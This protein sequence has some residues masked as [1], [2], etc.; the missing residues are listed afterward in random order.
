MR[1][2]LYQTDSGNRPVNERIGGFVEPEGIDKTVR[3]PRPGFTILSLNTPV[4][5]ELKY[6][7]VYYKNLT[8]MPSFSYTVRHLLETHPALA[9]L[10]ATLYTTA[11]AKNEPVGLPSPPTGRSDT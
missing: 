1:Q 11:R 4:P 8:K 9:E 3:P 2:E 6:L 5:S 7:I 10:A